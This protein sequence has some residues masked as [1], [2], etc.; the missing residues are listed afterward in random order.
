VPLYFLREEGR[1][2]EEK[3]SQRQDSK[4]RRGKEAPRII[5]QTSCT[6]NLTQIA[7][8]EVI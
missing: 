6:F 1:G 7:Y 5:I 3:R 4:R 8:I 2:K